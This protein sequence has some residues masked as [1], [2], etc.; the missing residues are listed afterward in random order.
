L[1]ATAAFSEGELEAM[2]VLTRE[3]PPPTEPPTLKEAVRMVAK[4]GGHLGRKRDAEPG[5]T[6][7]WRGWLQLYI[8]VRVVSRMRRA[9]MVNSVNSS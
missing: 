5:V 2:H 1:P 8:A 9:G 4:M 3:G 7:M 6:V